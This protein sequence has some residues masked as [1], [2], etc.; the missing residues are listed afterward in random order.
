[1]DNE[2]NKISHLDTGKTIEIFVLP[3]LIDTVKTILDEYRILTS[4]GRWLEFDSHLYQMAITIVPGFLSKN[5]A[6]D[7]VKDVNTKLRYLR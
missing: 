4:F 7:I 3:H 1:M 6:L 5:E 2:Q